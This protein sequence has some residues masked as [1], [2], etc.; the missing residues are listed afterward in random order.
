MDR[1]HDVLVVTCAQDRLSTR[2][3][4][5]ALLRGDWH[6]F[7]PQATV[8]GHIAN[9]GVP[10]KVLDRP[11]AIAASDVPEADFIIAT[12]WETAVWMHGMPISKGKRVHLIQG[13]EVWLGQ[14]VV[15][16]VNETLRLPN[17]KIAISNDLKTTIES[18][19]GHIGIAV[20]PNAVDLQQFD[21][22]QR[23]RNNPPKAGFVYATAA[24]KG[25]DVCIRACE[26]AREKIPDLHVVAFGADE[27]TVELP[28]PSGAEFF[29]RPAQTDLKKIYGQCD[30]WLFGSRLDSFGLPILE[31]MACRTPVIAVPIGA[32]PDLLGDGTGIMVA[33]ESPEE[34]A[35]AI[36]EMC[37]QPAARWQQYS[38]QSYAK[39]HSYS[40]VDATSKMLNIL[41]V[42]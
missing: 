37:T 26:L 7:R 21:A 4:F 38:D 10:H 15:A 8:P 35:A 17:V 28:L 14:H 31:A 12:W 9:S 16:R 36:V 13:Y 1:G 40:W 27:P 39:A 3:K 5:G 33:N 20:V 25:A 42:P 19:V 22:P 18:A 2:Q 30:V 29:H 34:M 23:L 41:S 11:R 6:K 24:I 32:A